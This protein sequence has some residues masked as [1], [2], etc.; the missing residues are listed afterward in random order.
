[1]WE[2]GVGVGV[3]HGARE[4]GG[5][6]ASAVITWGLA[7]CPE[8]KHHERVHFPP[9]PPI[10]HLSGHSCFQLGGPAAPR[11]P[12]SGEKPPEWLTEEQAAGVSEHLLSGFC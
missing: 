9:S 1:M 6:S 11:V 10:P 12:F 7:I 3:A 4:S 8:D 2:V 5:C